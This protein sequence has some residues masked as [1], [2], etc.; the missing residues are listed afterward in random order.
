MPTNNGDKIRDYFGQPPKAERDDDVLGYD[1]QRDK[2][3]EDQKRLKK[4]LKND[5]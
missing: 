2:E 5:D 4:R 1:E 3:V